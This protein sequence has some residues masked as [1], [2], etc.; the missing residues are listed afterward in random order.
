VSLAE[1]LALTA[2]GLLALVGGVFLF[3]AAIGLVRLPDDGSRTHALRLA[4]TWGAG[5]M[6]LA[7]AVAGASWSVAFKIALLAGLVWA[8]AVVAGL[9]G[10]AAAVR[11]DVDLP[12]GEGS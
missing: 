7:L 12:P 1:A 9:A 4:E 10:G 3:A 2:G 6:L 11:R 8:G 5:L